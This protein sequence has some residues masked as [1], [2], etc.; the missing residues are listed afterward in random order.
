[1]LIN[2][3]FQIPA[4]RSV[5][6]CSSSI[7]AFNSPMQEDCNSFLSPSISVSSVASYT[8]PASADM[9]SSIN[10]ADYSREEIS[11]TAEELLKTFRFEE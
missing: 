6:L 5:S 2:H 11:C 3:Q 10:S 8:A 9:N 1:M 7:G 4:S